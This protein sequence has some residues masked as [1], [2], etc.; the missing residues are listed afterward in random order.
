ML[1]R[2]EVGS[3]RCACL[4]HPPLEG[5]GQV[6]ARYVVAEAVLGPHLLQALRVIHNHLTDGQAGVMMGAH[7]NGRQ[8]NTL[9]H[10]RT[11]RHI[12]LTHMYTHTHV[13]THMCTRAHLTDAHVHTRAHTC[14]PH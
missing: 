12:S 10:T 3:Q 4:G 7:V 6:Y 13:H 9:T 1:W 2:D 8:G 11:H 14:P 5:Q